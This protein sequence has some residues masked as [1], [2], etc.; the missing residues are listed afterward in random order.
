M[1]DDL[2]VLHPAMPLGPLVPR[3]HCEFAVFYLLYVVLI[4]LSICDPHAFF[5]RL[6][7][8]RLLGRVV[9]VSDPPLIGM[10]ISVVFIQNRP[11]GAPQGA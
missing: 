8:N 11:P 4:G 2:S 9:L 7:Q 5:D 1:N 6:F 3:F 10:R